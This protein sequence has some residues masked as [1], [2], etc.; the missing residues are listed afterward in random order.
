MFTATKDVLLP[1][2][3]TG[4][5]PRPAWYTVNL[6]GKPLSAR[7]NDVV[8]RE[9]FFDAVSAVVSDQERAGLDIITNGDYHHDHDFAGRAWLLYPFE[10]LAG[11]APVALEGSGDWAYPAGTMLNEI[12]GGWRYPA[13][14]DRIGE[15]LPFEFDKV[16][17]I[18]QA[19]T[20]KPVK[21]GSVSAQC[22]T[23][24]ASLNTDAYKADKHD[25]MW[26]MAG[27]FNREYRRLADAGCKVIQLEEPLIHF[28][29]ATTNDAGYLDFLVECF[30]HEIEGLDDVEV[31]VHSCWGNPNMQKVLENTEYEH[32][33]ELYMERVN[34]DV[35]TIESKDNDKPALSLFERYKGDWPANKK[36]AVGVVS[37]RTLSADQPE[38]VAGE[39]RRALENIP[40]ENLVLSTDCGFGR[41]GFNRLVA[42]Y[43]TTAIAQ[44]ANIVR[45]ELGLPEAPVRAADPDLQVE[46]K[47][48]AG[49]PVFEEETTAA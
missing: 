8:Y 31:W 32:S 44:G 11:V 15:R 41:G 46:D 48:G 3:V 26:E 18:A 16:W 22:V 1:T 37:H 7:L 30:N 45:R 13:V 39:V 38:D 6:E 43:K 36:V 5:W 47:A 40:V 25:L 9:Q 2:T 10:R 35:W 27:I 42:F 49:R 17:R 28:T 34:A 14:V 12:M 20:E 4:S 33:L 21:F 29:A 23:S 24:V 19:R